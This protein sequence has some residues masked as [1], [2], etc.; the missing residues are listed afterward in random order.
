MLEFFILGVLNTRSLTKIKNGLLVTSVI[1]FYL[2]LT[3]MVSIAG[4]GI[5][6]LHF[7]I[8][9]KKTLIDNFKE[10]SNGLK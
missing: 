5:L 2:I 8:K 7:D 4:I 3:F 1:V 10:F 6:K 9:N